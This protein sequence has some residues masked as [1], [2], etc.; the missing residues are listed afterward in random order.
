MPQQLPLGDLSRF[1]TPANFSTAFI[2]MNFIAFAA[3][4]I[5]KALAENGR[6]R[7]RESTLLMFAFLGGMPGAY[8]GRALFRHKTRKQPF[9]DNLHAI[10]VIQCL[11]LAGGLAWWHGLI[12]PLA[13]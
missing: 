12:P 8:A 10:A 4:G 3:F 5:D 9:S 1:A 2:A 13:L 6:R 11:A 7:I